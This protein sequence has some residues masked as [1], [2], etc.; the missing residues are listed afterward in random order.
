MSETFRPLRRGRQALSRE[1]CDII[2][3][4]TT[5]G[6]LSLT[7][8]GG[9]PYGVPLNHCWDGHSLFFHCAREGHK[10]DALRAE[11]RA[12]YTV[13]EQDRIV[14][15]RYTTAYRSVIVFGRLRLITDDDEKRDI[16]V[17]MTETLCPSR[18]DV[19]NIC[20]IEPS[21]SRVVVIEL[22]AEHITGK[23]GRELMVK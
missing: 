18:T 19:Q 20:E 17:Q 21:L 2:L 3:N 12:S 6:V 7:G 9:W 1:Q 8:D 5:C 13:I 11:P 14:E 15:E 4:T 22:V 16:L 10:L 23:Q